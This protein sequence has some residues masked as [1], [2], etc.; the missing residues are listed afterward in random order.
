MTLKDAV[1]Q[2]KKIAKEAGVAQHVNKIGN[3]YEIDDFYDSDS[4]VIS[5]EGNREFNNALSPEEKA[6]LKE[7]V[8]R[9]FIQKEIKNV[10]KENKSKISKRK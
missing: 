10:L 3:R 9:K 8:L 2:A 1:T 4:T 6:Q 7:S 5:F